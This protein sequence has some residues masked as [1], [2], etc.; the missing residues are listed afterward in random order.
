MENYI[1]KNKLYKINICDLIYF[2]EYD[3]LL[4]N[5]KRE[6]S[7]MVKHMPFKHYY[8]GSNPIVLNLTCY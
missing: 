7:L 2:L 3:Y 6:L 1:T 8:M 5:K 4:N